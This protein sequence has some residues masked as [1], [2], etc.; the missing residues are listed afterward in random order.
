[1]IAGIG[2]I[3][4]DEALWVARLHPRRL[5]GSL[6]ESESQALF[7]AIRCV[8]RRGIRNKGTSMGNGA[9]NYRR[10]DEKRGRNQDCLMIVRERGSVCPVC[11]AVITR[12]L[13]GQ[14][15]TYFCPK[16]QK[17]RARKSEPQRSESQKTGN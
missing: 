14:R 7:K 12:T 2:N 5:S 11:R 1:M 8:L 17:L 6:K 4:A 15:A 16:C 13:V 10:L 9:G 3:Y